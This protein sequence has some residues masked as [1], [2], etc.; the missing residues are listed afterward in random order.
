MP[1]DFRHTEPGRLE[2]HKLSLLPFA[3]QYLEPPAV[4]LTSMPEAPVI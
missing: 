3:F 4:I 1:T 2:K